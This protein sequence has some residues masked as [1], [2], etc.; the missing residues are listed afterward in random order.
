MAIVQIGWCRKP[1]DPLNKII[2]HGDI[3]AELAEIDHLSK[4]KPKDAPAD[5]LPPPVYNLT[6]EEVDELLAD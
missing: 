2:C 3:I 1:K 5:D 6:D 4:V